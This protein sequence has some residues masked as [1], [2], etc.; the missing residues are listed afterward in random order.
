MMKSKALAGLLL[1]TVAHQG[2]PFLT[3][4]PAAVAVHGLKPYST[5]LASFRRKDQDLHSLMLHRPW[6]NDLFSFFDDFDL[7][8]SSNN[9]QNRSPRGGMAIDFKETNE[10]FELICDLPGVE[11]KDIDITLKNNELTISAHR[12]S[13]KKED[14]ANY[15]RVERHSGHIRRTVALPENADLDK[16]T[17]ENKNGVLHVMVK[18]T[19]VEQPVE[20]KIELTKKTEN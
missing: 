17:A 14:G 3:Y 2:R 20:K 10:T 1:T 5:S 19:A 13:S 18:K 9:G 6:P 12:E 7:L 4:F 16:I 15:H 8:P 11:E